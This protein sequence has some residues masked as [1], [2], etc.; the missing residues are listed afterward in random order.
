MWQF[1]IRSSA[2]IFQFCGPHDFIAE[3][4]TQI[5][6]RSKIDRKAP[7]QFREFSLEFGQAKKSRD[8]VGV[9][10]HEEIHIAFRAGIP[11]QIR[12]EQGETANAVVLAKAGQILSRKL[13]LGRHV[14]TSVSSP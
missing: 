1:R 9:E 7:E 11:L 2:R 10:L 12:T 6:G 5:G 13:K 14:C 4:T 8:S 3:I